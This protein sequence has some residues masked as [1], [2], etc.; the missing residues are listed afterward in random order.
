MQADDVTLPSTTFV[1]GSIS[2]CEPRDSLCLVGDIGGTNT[3]LLLLRV[4]AEA[5]ASDLA[6]GQK[7]P[8]ELVHKARFANENYATFVSVVQEFVRDARAQ[9]PAYARTP[10]QSACFA[11]AG[12]VQDGEAVLSN[13]KSWVFVES[14]LQAE[15]GISSVRLVNDFAAVGYGLL[16]LEPAELVTLQDAPVRANAPIAC[17]GAGTGLGECFMVRMPGTDYEVF[18]S[19]GGHAEFAPR[20][21][22]EIELLSFLRTKYREPHRV[23][24][25]RVVSGMGLA[26][27]YE[28]LRTKFPERVNADVDAAF[29][30]A[31][32]QRGGVVAQAANAGDSLCS[33]AMDI[34]LGAYGAEAG[35][36]ALKFLPFGGLYIAGGIAP[37]NRERIVSGQ[38]FM[39][40]FHDKGRLSPLL[41]RIP[42]HIVLNEDVGQRGAYLVAVR[43]L[44]AARSHAGAS[45][46]PAVSS[47]AS[48]GAAPSSGAQRS[49]DW[50]ST[51]RPHSAPSSSAT[52]QQLREMGFSEAQISAAVAGVSAGVDTVAACAAFIAAS[53]L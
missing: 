30:A 35:V 36:A 37:K 49:A 21:E 8:G 47:G 5:L 11:V 33:Q 22:L 10:I 28:F 46:M 44:K 23:S 4:P 20:S 43:A 38:E 9:V 48:S 29:L 31:E 50:V 7:P 1:D 45:A 15:L 6:M 25:E 18:P 42:L 39:A 53:G 16:T 14:A 34:M 17:I 2:Q 26:N 19:E 12:P 3:R 41:R 24:V 27:L 52:A 32:D 40:A 51:V 13:R